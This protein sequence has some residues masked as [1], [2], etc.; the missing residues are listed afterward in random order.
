MFAS[1]NCFCIQV[2]DVMLYLCCR[3]EAAEPVF[4][5]R[6]DTF[7]LPCKHGKNQVRIRANR[8]RAQHPGR[9]HR[10][11]SHVTGTASCE[12]GPGAVATGAFRDPP[13]L[14]ML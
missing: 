10:S 14:G 3:A 2:V 4:Y 11:M 6:T 8:A 1:I 12:H 5:G 9:L 13:G 7:S